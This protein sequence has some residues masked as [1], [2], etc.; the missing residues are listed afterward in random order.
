MLRNMV[1]AISGKQGQNKLEKNRKEREYYDLPPP[2]RRLVFKIWFKNS[3]KVYYLCRYMI[4]DVSQTILILD[5]NG[6]LRY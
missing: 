2:H 4:D 6:R 3:F 5:V 1:Q